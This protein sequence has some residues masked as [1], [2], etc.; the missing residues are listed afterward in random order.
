MKTIKL[1][2]RAAACPEWSRSS[3]A[4]AVAL[5]LLGGPAAWAQDAGDEDAQGKRVDNARQVRVAMPPPSEQVP[6]GFAYELPSGV[7][8]ADAEAMRAANASLPQA[9]AQ[10]A[11]ALADQSGALFASGKADLTDA[12][13]AALD[14]VIAKLQGKQ[15]VRIAV[16]GHTDSQRLAPAT[17]RLFRDNQGLSEARALAVASYLRNGLGLPADAVAMRGHGETQPV[18][19]NGNLQGM[20]QNRRVEIALW[21]EEP[22]AAAP[23]PAPQAPAD[24]CAPS[25][26]VA[27]LPFRVTVDG[28]R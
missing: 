23:A 24:Q 22:V 19:S 4:A 2:G 10:Q 25:A 27:D 17:K 5:V 14:A 12:S 3:V 20:A 16:V 9:P 13:R 28:G 18:A 6:Q 8:R 11:V 21:W 26:A 15:A 7:T 1:N